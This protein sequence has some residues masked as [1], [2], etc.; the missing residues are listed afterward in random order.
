[1]DEN[2]II[3]I[4]IIQFQDIWSFDGQHILSCHMNFSITFY[5]LFSVRSQPQN[6]PFA[7]SESSSEVQKQQSNVLEEEASSPQEILRDLSVPLETIKSSTFI[8]A[9]ATEFY[10]DLAGFSLCFFFLLS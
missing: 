6:P 10:E 1:M 3:I 7:G 5:V 9:E 4:I 2:I 8:K